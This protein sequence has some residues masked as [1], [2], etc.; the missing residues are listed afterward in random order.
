MVKWRYKLQH[1]LEGSGQCHALAT[2]SHSQ[3]ASGTHCTEGCMSSSTTLGA[4]AWIPPRGTESNSVIIQPICISLGIL[5][6]GQIQPLNI[7]VLMKSV[8]GTCSQKAKVTSLQTLC[9]SLGVKSKLK[10]DCSLNLTS[11]NPYQIINV[12]LVPQLRLQTD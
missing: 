8:F 4:G 12:L 1:W 7:F 2:L 6:V 10:E 5:L 9:R 3:R 11:Y